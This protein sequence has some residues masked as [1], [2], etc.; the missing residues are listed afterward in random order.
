MGWQPKAIDMELWKHDR[1]RVLSRQDG[2][3][4]YHSIL[5]LLSSS[6]NLDHGQL[7]RQVCDKMEEMA[8]T[9]IGEYDVREWIEQLQNTF[10]TLEDYIE[11]QR[12]NKAWAGEMELIL[13]SSMYNLNIEIF[14]QELS[15]FEYVHTY[16]PLLIK[17]SSPVGNNSNVM[18]A[19][20]DR[21]HYEPLILIPPETSFKELT[22]TSARQSK[23]PK[24]GGGPESEHK[25]EESRPEL[26]SESKL[27]KKPINTKTNLKSQSLIKG[28]QHSFKDEFLTDDEIDQYDEPKVQYI[29]LNY[30][31]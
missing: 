3:C 15:K 21:R 25:E 6:V 11:N 20:I 30:H 31:Q 2:N 12:R 7:R 24:E 4:L 17:D 16:K 23:K 8:D 10:K 22:K 1:V 14:N 19:F 27:I 29:A 28:I 9:K 26:I 13:L 18:L 5:Y